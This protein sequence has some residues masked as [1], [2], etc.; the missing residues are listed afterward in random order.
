[1][2]RTAAGSASGNT[3]ALLDLDLSYAGLPQT[4]EQR[5]SSEA[6]RE[7]ESTVMTDKQNRVWVS[8]RSRPI[9]ATVLMTTFSFMISIAVV[10][11]VAVSVSRL[12][13]IKSRVDEIATSLNISVT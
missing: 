12:N 10:A 6:A 7:S 8:W 2:R 11:I 1:M 3:A 4:E 5:S 9:L 13:E